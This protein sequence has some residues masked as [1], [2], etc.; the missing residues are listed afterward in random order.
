NTGAAAALIISATTGTG[1]VKLANAVT[2]LTANGS[3]TLDINNLS[4][5]I[6]DVT[7]GTLTLT[8]SGDGTAG[9]VTINKA[10]TINGA[11]ATIAEAK[12]FLSITVNAATILTAFTAGAGSTVSTLTNNGTITTLTNNGTITTLNGSGTY[13]NLTLG[14]AG[15]ISTALTD[16]I[17]ITNITQT[18]IAANRSIDL[19]SY[20]KA[21]AA[22]GPDAAGANSLTLTSA[23]GAATINV[24]GG[25]V[26]LSGVLTGD[27]L[28]IDAT[29]AAKVLAGAK[30]IT[31][32]A[33]SNASDL[34]TTGTL[35]I[36]AN[37]TGKLTLGAAPSAITANGNADIDGAGDIAIVIED[38][39]DSKTLTLSKTHVSTPAITLKKTTLTGKVVISDATKYGVITKDDGDPTNGAAPTNANLQV[40]SGAFTV[41]AVGNNATA[42]DT[43][44]IAASTGNLTVNNASGTVPG[45]VNIDGVITGTASTGAASIITVTANGNFTGAISIPAAFTGAWNS[46]SKDLTGMITIGGNPAAGTITLNPADLTFNVTGAIAMVTGPLKSGGGVSNIDV[47]A[48]MTNA[49]GI[50]NG[51]VN[52]GAVTL[53]INTASNAN[54][55]GTGTL[56]LQDDAGGTAAL[57]KITFNISAAN[58]LTNIVISQGF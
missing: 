36:S 13:A 48:T 51:K 10:G 39:A 15:A 49:N 28:N 43:L 41:A 14:T 25:F 54:L 9:A 53:S 45:I 4:T 21:I 50:Y 16:T 56:T 8:N 6:I 5:P 1:S 52:A 12:T 24:K 57:G 32:A 55:T 46:V 18:G 34:S 42:G 27:T 22:T 37:L 17:T 31:V 47:A 2:A 11:V 20:A 44:T 19:G 58:A 3:S 40:S 7:A 35:T 38:V 26:N 33:L 23:A 30:N 29:S